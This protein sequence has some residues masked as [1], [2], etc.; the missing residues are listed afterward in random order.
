MRRQIQLAKI[1][2]LYGFCFHHY[3]FHGKRLLE[4]PVDQ[5]LADTSL[6]FPFCLCWANENWTRRWDGAEHEVLI[7]QEHSPEDDTAFFAETSPGYYWDPRYIKLEGKPVLVVYRPTLLPSAMETVAR[8][9]DE[10][11]KRG[12]P[13]LFLVASNAFGFTDPTIIGF[14]AIVEFP[15]HGRAANTINHSLKL[16]NSDYSG[17]VYDYEEI[18]QTPYHPYPDNALV[19]PGVMPSWDNEPRR[20]G[21]GNVMHGSTPEVFR[22]WLSK[23]FD[24][25]RKNPS[26]SGQFVFINAWN[27]WAESGSLKPDQSFG[28]AYLSAVSNCIRA[29]T[30][31][32]AK[33]R[34]RAASSI[35]EW[36][37][38]APN[39]CIAHFYY[40][41]LVDEILDSYCCQSDLDL[42]ATVPES[43]SADDLDRI[44]RRVPNARI[45]VVPNRGRDVWPFIQ[46]LQ[47]VAAHGYEF[48]CQSSYK[49]ISAP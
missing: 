15:P 22:N 30:E 9:R 2:G 10:A 23:C 14:D 13:D 39:V 27:E 12:F 38:I 37:R 7:A 28:Y 34:R 17:A 36:R 43:W 3:W 11:R 19:I 26:E 47:Q 42:C 41:D 45:I 1:Y 20:P 32:D 16:F 46:A 33:L 44:T 25:A 48:Q 18:A 6:D 8:W 40:V 4:K 24:R 31:V 29:H 5:L 49:E 21:R 35:A